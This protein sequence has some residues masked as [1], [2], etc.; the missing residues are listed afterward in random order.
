MMSREKD[1]ICLLP[2]PAGFGDALIGGSFAFADSLLNTRFNQDLVG[3]SSDMAFVSALA[4][5]QRSLN[6]VSCRMDTTL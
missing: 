2:V 5:E 4:R 1:H 6:S 3:R